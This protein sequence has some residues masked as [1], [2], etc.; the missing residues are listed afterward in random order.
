MIDDPFSEHDQR[1]RLASVQIGARELRPGDAVILRP[2]GRADILDLALVGKLA[3]IET[4]EQDLEGRVYVAVTVDDDPGKQ[5]GM[6]WRTA[7]RF[8]FGI[9]ELEPVE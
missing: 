1:D 9:N 7:H 5:F 6:E 4:L 8:F 3:T 2:Q